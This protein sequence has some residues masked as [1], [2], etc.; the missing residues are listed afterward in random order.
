MFVGI[1]D[2]KDE[3][4]A[5]RRWAG[6]QNIEDYNQHIQSLTEVQPALPMELAFLKAEGK[7][8]YVLRISL[9]KSQ[10]VHKASDNTV[11]GRKGA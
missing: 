7:Q 10:A 1:A 5:S 8:G 9:E 4:V 3:L 2:E 11:Y 6:A